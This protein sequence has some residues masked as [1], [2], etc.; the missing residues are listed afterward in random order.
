[1]QP[2]LLPAL[3]ALAILFPSGHGA[4]LFGLC[5]RIKGPHVASAPGDATYGP[6]PQGP[7]QLPPEA[8]TPTAVALPDTASKMSTATEILDSLLRNYDHRL[9]PGIGERPTV[10]TV[11]LA[12]N[13][14]GPISIIDMEYSIDITLCQTW[15]DERLRYN[16]SFDSFVLSG[17][18]VSQLWVPDTFFRNSKRVYEQMFATPNQMVRIHPD[19]KVLYTIRMGIDA[20]CALHMFKYP[21]DSHTC[22]LSFSSCEYLLRQRFLRETAEVTAQGQA[23]TRSVLGKALAERNSPPGKRGRGPRPARPEAGSEAWL[24]SCWP[25]PRR[26]PAPAPTLPCCLAVSYTKDEMV[27]KWEDFELEINEENS[28]KLFQFDFTGVSN[29]TETLTTVSGDYVVLTLFF[30]VTRRFGF[31]AFQNYVPSSVTTMLSWVSFWIRKD[32]APARTSLGITSVLTMT[33][34]GSFTRK[35]FPRVSYITALDFYIAVCF[36]F[37]FCALMEFAVLN[38]LTYNRMRTRRSPKLRHVRHV[39]GAVARPCRME[40]PGLFMRGLTRA[41]VASRA[42]ARALQQEAFV[43]QVEEPVEAEEEE[44]ELQLEGLS[45]PAQQSLGLGS[46]RRASGCCRWYQKYLC[47]VPRCQGGLW[48][49]GRLY[50]HVYRLDNYS[51]VLFPVTFFFFNVLYW[52]VCLN[53]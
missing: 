21:L 14:L 19:G 43:C 10:V 18:L 28:W 37:C 51:R 49:K 35:H 27:Y 42:R 5:S 47:T 15:Y 20:G 45:C 3:L 2:K 29:K 16:G 32:S 25:G 26:G 52:L 34:L 30:N 31:V 8:S 38:F 50:I 46:A 13:T 53:L 22:P 24:V 48:Q 12:V 36:V 4:A 1:M 41:R 44:Q 33:T 23:P 6:R 17:N 7:E 40:A 39:C 11:R 9:R